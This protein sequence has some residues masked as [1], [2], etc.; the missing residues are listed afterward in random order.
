MHDHNRPSAPNYTQ[1]FL[2]TLGLILFMAF[3][4]IAALAGFLWVVLTAAVI[5]RAI[6]VGARLRR[7]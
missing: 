2:V 5:D 4:T 1:P 6:L 3:W 7:D